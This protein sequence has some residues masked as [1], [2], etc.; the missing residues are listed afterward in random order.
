VTAPDS[1]FFARRRNKASPPVGKR[2]CADRWEDHGME[3]FIAGL[4][5]DFE[6]GKLDRREFCQ[7]VESPPSFAARAKPPM[8]Q[9][10][11]GFKMIGINH[12]S[13]SCSDYAKARDFYAARLPLSLPGALSIPGTGPREGEG[14]TA[15]AWCG[16]R[17]PRWCLQPPHDRPDWLRRAD[18]RIGQ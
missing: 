11:R 1:A 6:N 15:V 16:K 9:P 7:T 10:T 14:G 17:S 18:Q 3:P 4:A 13:Y 2:Q 8:P 5:K 12:N